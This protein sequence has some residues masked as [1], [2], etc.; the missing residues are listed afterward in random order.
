MGCYSI[1]DNGEEFRFYPRESKLDNKF[2]K[3]VKV[4]A[5]VLLINILQDQ[6]IT[7]GSN[8]QVCIWQLQLND[9]GKYISLNI[10]Y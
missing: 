6:L 3:I 9:N 7:L 5:P 1:L 10:L 8:A 4:L 2:A